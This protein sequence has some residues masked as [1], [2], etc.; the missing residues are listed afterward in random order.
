MRVPAG[1]ED[2]RDARAFDRL[3]RMLA[4]P[5]AGKAAEQDQGGRLVE[6]CPGRG[7]GLDQQR[8]PLDLGE[9]ADVERGPCRRAREIGAPRRRRSRAAR[10]SPALRPLDQVRRQCAPRSIARG[11][12]AGRSRSGRATKRS[13]SRSSRGWRPRPPGLLTTIRVAARRPSRRA[14]RPR[15]S[16]WPNPPAIPR[17]CARASAARSHG[18]GRSPAC[19]ANPRGRFVQRRQVVEVEEV[20]RAALAARAR[21]SRHRPGARRRSS[22]SLAITGSSAPGRSS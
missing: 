3:E 8:Q 21:A 16:A 5:L 2:I 20:G 1:E 15:W 12:K 10:P 18:C 7:E 11:P 17:R 9:A 13:G 22:P 6:S 14:A 19:R 4:L